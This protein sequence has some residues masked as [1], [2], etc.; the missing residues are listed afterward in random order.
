VTH[1]RQQLGPG[2]ILDGRYRLEQ[3]IAHG[4]FG[5]VYRA[6]HLE[7][8]CD[9]AI[10]VLQPSYATRSAIGA[11]FVREGQLL[12]RLRHP[13]TVSIYD[14]GI[15]GDTMYIAM[16]LLA[17]GTLHDRLTSGPLGWIQAVAVAQGVCCALTEAHALG[18]VHRDLKPGNIH[19]EPWAGG[20]LVKVIDFGVAK[21]TRG[22]SIHASIRSGEE[23]DLTHYGQ[24]LGTPEYMAPEQLVAEGVDRR[25]DIYALGVVLYEMLTGQRPFDVGGNTALLLVQIAQY[26]PNRPSLIVR[27]AK[28]AIARELDRIVLRCLAAD[29]DDRFQSI[30]QL[31]A[32]LESLVELAQLPTIPTDP[33]MPSVRISSLTQPPPSRRFA[34][35]T[36]VPEFED[37][38]ERVAA[39]SA[40]VGERTGRT[41][42][43]AMLREPASTFTQTAVRVRD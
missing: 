6:T 32:V 18:I 15:A 24:V 30:E 17:G 41:A 16:E 39:A 37:S 12:Q 7:T 9:I 43:R 8:G 10:K 31:S 3:L 40:G 5:S 21:V 1:S 19:L 28:G 33:T 42:I 2:S 11:R 38:P 23:D 27:Y 4:G 20:E 26:T 22:S 25:T 35:G 13:N 34:L 14:L 36:V 29:P